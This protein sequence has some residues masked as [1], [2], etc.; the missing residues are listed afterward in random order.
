MKEE[1]GPNVSFQAPILKIN[2]SSC[3]ILNSTFE[4]ISTA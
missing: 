4:N 3:K 2:F 1:I